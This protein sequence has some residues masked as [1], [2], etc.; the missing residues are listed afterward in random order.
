LASALEVVGL[1]PGN[2]AE[3]VGRAKLIEE[4]L[5]RVVEDGH[6]SIGNLRDA[7]SRNQMKLPDLA[8]PTELIGGD[9]LIRLNRKLAV[10]LDGIY[11]RGEF[12]MRLLHRLSSVAFGTQLGRWLVLFLIL[13]FGLAF[14]VMI[15]PGIAIEEGEKLTKLIHSAFAGVGMAEEQPAPAG[16]PTPHEFPLPNLWGVGGLGVFFLLLFHVAGF[17]SRFFYALG[18]V[19]QGLGRIQADAVGLIHLPAVQAILHNRYW[20]LFRRCVLWPGLMAVNGGLLAWWLELGNSTIGGV[21]ATGLVFGLI[22]FNTR[23]ARDLEESV[24]DRLL[25]YWAWISVDF[26]PGLLRLIMDLSRRCLDAVE[27]LLYA[28]NERLRFRGGENRVVVAGK[29]VVG[30][31]WAVVAYVVRFAINL[32]IEPQVN[33]IKHFPV[34]TVSHKVCLPM[35][36]TLAGV[37]RN[38]TAVTSPTATATAIVFGIPG[39][40]G[41][42]VWELKENWKLYASNRSAALKPVLIGSHG[43][44]MLRLPHPGFHSGTI[45]KL[46][47]RLR[48]AERHG[49]QRAIRKNLAEL[50]HVEAGIAHFIERELLALLRR[51]KGWDGLAVELAAIHLATNQVLVELHCSTL[52]ANAEEKF[53]FSFDH[54]G[55]WLIAGA[56]EPGWL[57]RLSVEQQ[58]TLASA[59]AGLYRLAGVQMTREQIAASLPLTV[60][61][62]DI[63]DA[64]LVVWT[65]PDGRDEFLYDLNGGPVVQPMPIHPEMP[66]LNTHALLLANNPLAW[67]DWV[68][69]CNGSEEC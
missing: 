60:F 28:V 69:I 41:F 51:S 14:F 52:R 33:P 24:T 5:D 2:V 23:V 34:V 10:S 61:A 47:K 63:A 66:A 36:P 42:M 29:A 64:G 17:R 3:D 45:P 30:L 39:I 26:L 49:Q 22:L 65:G 8:G 11:R 59:L 32:L 27:R 13:P 68:Q 31:V 9:P 21:A 35:I 67:Q 16:H 15:T 6:F 43:E 38:T 53:V 1:T 50:H 37:L 40:F 58:R 54:Q 19:G 46:F 57:P 48:R 56:V 44:T 12:Y 7:V 62:F 18:K 25:R 20:R 55:G 4:L